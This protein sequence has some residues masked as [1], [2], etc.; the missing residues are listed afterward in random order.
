MKKLI[1]VIFVSLL[2]SVFVNAQTDTTKK[3][4]TDKQTETGKKAFRPTKTQITAAQEKLKA[5]KSTA[6]RQTAFI[7][8]I[9]ALRSNSIKILTV[10]IK[11]EN[12]MKKRS[13]KWA[14]N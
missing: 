11:M 5:A 2:F 4:T 8:M 6:A 10:L 13:L 1:F 3:T 12:S 14:S 9:S 7:T